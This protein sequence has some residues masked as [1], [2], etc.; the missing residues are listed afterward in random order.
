MAEEVEPEEEK[1]VDGCRVGCS[2]GEE[3]SRVV[4]LE[5]DKANA[6]PSGSPRLLVGREYVGPVLELEADG[7][8]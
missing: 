2:E 8:V 1:S 6:E 7:V 5:G 3:V 4:L